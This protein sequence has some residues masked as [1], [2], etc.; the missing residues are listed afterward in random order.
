MYALRQHLLD[1]RMSDAAAR[2]A[3]LDPGRAAHRA[4][5]PGLRAARAPP[6]PGD[7]RPAAGRRHRRRRADRQRQRRSR[8]ASTCRSS[9][10]SAPTTGAARP[11]ARPGAPA[12]RRVLGPR[13]Q[14]RPALDLAAARLPDAPRR[15]DAWGGMRARRPGPPRA[16]A[17]VLAEV[18]RRGPL[19]AARS[20][21]PSPT[22]CPARARQWGWNWSL[23]KNA[24]EHLFWAGE[25]SS[26]GRTTRSSAAT[27]AEPGAAAGQ[28]APALDP[29]ARPSEDEALPPAR[30]DLRP[31][32]RGRHRS[33]AC[34]TTS[35]SRR[36][37][38]RPAIAA[39]VADGTL[40]P[41]TVEGWHRPVYLH[42][43]ARRPRRVHARALLP[44]S[45]PWSGSATAPRP[46]RLRLPARD[47]R[48]RGA[49]RARLLRA[50]V[51]AR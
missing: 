2:R 7:P 8:A 5:G 28:R 36:E 3:P 18:A 22:T 47:L 1:R 37:Q 10:G 39:L 26:A 14:P 6:L 49:A 31:G 24:L 4:R 13:G 46:L 45:T 35:G 30:R 23:V 20:R 33:S 32:A 17:G 16:V 25:V 11:G 40:L 34:A 21:S 19:T 41:A 51:P 27:P 43:D 42:R 29:A 48:A 50:A 38:A 9:P 12:G 44:R 15:H